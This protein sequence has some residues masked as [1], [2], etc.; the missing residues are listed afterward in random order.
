MTSIR[1]TVEDISSVFS[2]FERS[3]SAH[4]LFGCKPLAAETLQRG[5]RP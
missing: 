2:R 3:L 5:A 1:T 4:L